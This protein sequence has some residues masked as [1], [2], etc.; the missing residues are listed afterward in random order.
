MV[1]PGT[2][3]VVAPKECAQAGSAYACIPSSATEEDI[4][5][6]SIGYGQSLYRTVFSRQD[7]KLLF[8]SPCDKKCDVILTHGANKSGYSLLNSAQ[9]VLLLVAV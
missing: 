7:L 5:K 3:V 1:F 9:R 8:R 4:A 6:Q 2:P